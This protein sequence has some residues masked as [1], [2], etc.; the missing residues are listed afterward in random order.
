M[1]RRGVKQARKKVGRGKADGEG[2]GWRGG[3]RDGVKRERKSWQGGGGGGKGS[4]WVACW[5]GGW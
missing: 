3:G 1:G 2:N 5:G 4:K